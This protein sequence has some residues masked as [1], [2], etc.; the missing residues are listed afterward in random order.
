MKAYITKYALTKGII[1]VDGFVNNEDIFFPAY[2]NSGAQYF[3][4]NEWTTTKRKALRIANT[5]RL[6]QI[7]SLQKEIER[8]KSLK[9][10]R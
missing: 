10:E 6:A 2:S 9:F 4:K 3:F 8:L 5:M 1:E 7:K